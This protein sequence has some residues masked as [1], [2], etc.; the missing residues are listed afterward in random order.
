MKIRNLFLK[1]KG[2]IISLII[3]LGIGFVGGIGNMSQEEYNG[4]IDQKKKLDSEI[5]LLD[6]QLS[7]VQNSVDTLQ[8]KKEEA[9]K[10][11][12]EEASRKA[13]EDAEKK[14]QE[15]RE[16]IAREEAERAAQNQQSSISYEVSGNNNSVVSETPIGEMVWLSATGAKYHR[17]NNCGNMNPNKAR[18]VTR[19]SAISSGFEACKKC[20]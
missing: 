1:N 14:A 20:Y 11:A 17:I 15:E 7:D 2:T 10:I 18:Q 3:A 5:V 13:K 19:D 4:V 9:E 6:K 8:E 16:R 12:K